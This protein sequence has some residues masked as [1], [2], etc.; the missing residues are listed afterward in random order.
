MSGPLSPM[1]D[2]GFIQ[3]RSAAVYECEPL[4]GINYIRR[5]KLRP[6]NLDDAIVIS[7]D[8]VP[9]SEDGK[10]EYEALSYVWGSPEQPEV[11]RVDEKYGLTISATRNLIMALQ[12]LRHTD[13]PRILRIDALCIN[14]QDDV[15]KGPQV[16]MMGDIYRHATRVV[17]WI[18]PEAD[19]S[20]LIMAKMESLGSLIQ[21]DFAGKV[22]FS[23]AEGATE[24][25]LD[26]AARSIYLSIEEI[27]AMVH[28][29]HR[30]WFSRLWIRQEVQLASSAAVITC[31][32]SQLSWP[33]FL[34]AFVLILHRRVEASENKGPIIEPAVIDRVRLVQ[35]QL[36][37][38]RMALIG[39]T[40]AGSKIVSLCD[41]RQN[42]ESSDCYD[43]RGR[44]YGIMSF[45]PDIREGI[46][47]DYT[48]P[49]GD[50]YKDAF[51]H[52]TQRNRDLSL[53]GSCKLATR[54][55]IPNWVPDW[56]RKSKCGTII[57]GQHASSHLASW[58]ELQNDVLRVAGVL[59][60]TIQYHDE[61][62]VQHSWIY[63]VYKLYE[64]LRRLLINLIH[65]EKTIT[66]DEKIKYVARTLVC[67][68]FADKFE[69]P[70]E[71]HPT[72]ES[73]KSIVQKIFLTLIKTTQ[74][75]SP[76]TR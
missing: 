50:V 10:P 61:F 13:E 11:V 63:G 19:N 37:E 34:R 57:N 47:P 27:D 21:V 36:V 52:Y 24:L 41:L 33:V 72:I 53:F 76:K 42:F 1:S 69:P 18:G 2:L 29:L 25:D 9:F 74:A 7:L 48:K 71:R 51:L 3:L 16:A 68:L 43:P 38:T 5:V 35:V 15:E 66:D 45:L 60:G 67:N 6:G 12:Y 44:I 56:S 31:G 28:L 58:H 62:R 54:S 14:Q 4:P 70:D 40:S 64:E 32:H 59:V 22:T 30:P 46:V 17:A 49:F 65:P 73:G 39:F 8:V 75:F 20:D 23:L 55:H 26:L